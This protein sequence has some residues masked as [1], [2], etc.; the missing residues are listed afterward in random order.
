MGSICQCDRKVSE[1]I[2]K[3]IYYK[4]IIYCYFCCDNSLVKEHLKRAKFWVK[5]CL[6]K[7][8]QAGNYPK[9]FPNWRLL[10]NM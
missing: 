4:Y 7:T 9:M 3:F 10:P 6:D 1:E 8:K 5:I 2:G